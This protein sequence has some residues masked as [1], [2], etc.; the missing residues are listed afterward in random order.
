MKK[1][2]KHEEVSVT[3]EAMVEAFGVFTDTVMRSNRL[4]GQRLR[5]KAWKDSNGHWATRHGLITAVIFTRFAG[6]LAAVRVKT[7]RGRY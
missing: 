2:W 4:R 6:R 7:E 1:A 5:V 3:D